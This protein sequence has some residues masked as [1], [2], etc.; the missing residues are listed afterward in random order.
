M[1]DEGFQN[2][3]NIDISPT[4]IKT[5]TDKYKDKG[6]TFKYLQ[7][8]VRAMDFA[9]NSFDVVID[10]ATLDSI[11]VI[12]RLY[13]VVKDQLITLTKQFLKSIEY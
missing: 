12:K 9:D 4:I 6:P 5:M 2:I 13:S 11:L 3:T 8:D 7:M 10:K 1:F